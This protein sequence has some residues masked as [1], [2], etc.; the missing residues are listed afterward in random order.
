[1]ISGVV[2][3]VAGLAVENSAS[4]VLARALGAMLACN[5]VGAMIG[6]IAHRTGTQHVERYKVNTPIP[7]IGG[8]KASASSGE[9]HEKKLAA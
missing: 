1:M 9:A 2:A 5:V 7:V 3:V 4:V 6:A 8:S